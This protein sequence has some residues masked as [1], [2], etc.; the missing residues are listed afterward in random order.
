M[1][2][3]VADECWVALAALARRD[4]SRQ[5]FTIREILAQIRSEN[6]Y[7][8]LRPGLGA[9]LHQ[10]NVAN[11]APST[12]RYR[13]FYRTED[14]G[15]R[16]YHPGDP[17]HPARRGKSHPSRGDLP[18]QYHELLDWYESVYCKGVREAQEED[19]ILRMRGLGKELWR[20][21]DADTYVDTLRSG[22]N[23]EFIET[24][25]EGPRV[26]IRDVWKRILR[27]QSEVF[28]TA[29][30]HPYTYRVEGDN[31]IWFYRNGHRIERRLSRSEL[32][33]ALKVPAIF[34]PSD[35]Q[36]FQCPSYLFGLI[37]DPRITG[38]KGKA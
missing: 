32:E 11:C 30:S 31:A 18:V 14:G 6:A 21:T 15:L 26:P 1:K 17:A 9:H 36:K 27:F 10:H 19:P 34:K 35:L 25:P 7:G 20:R 24:A 29:N 12:A 16:L 4:P 8:E 22:W 37:T 2:I 13:M 5:S 33:S 3:K 23:E 38:V 28:R